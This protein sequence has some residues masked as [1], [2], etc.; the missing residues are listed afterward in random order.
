M[1]INPKDNTLKSK[2]E[3]LIEKALRSGGFLF[4]V[5]IEEVKE[6]ERI[7]GT[8]DVLLPDELRE[9]TFLDN[10]VENQILKINAVKKPAF[11][12]AARG[13]TVQLSDEVKKKMAQDRRKADKEANY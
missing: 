11:A 2:Q 4:P 8:T 7:Y 9:P 1:A 12:L 6:F 5:T 3:R 10:K 13:A